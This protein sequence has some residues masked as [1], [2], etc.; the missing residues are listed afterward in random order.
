MGF[1]FQPQALQ[2]LFARVSACRGL[3]VGQRT[4]AHDALHESK[5][6]YG[7][8]A[9][10]VCVEDGALALVAVPR[11][12]AGSC[13]V[14]LAMAP[15]AQDEGNADDCHVGTKRNITT[16]FCGAKLAAVLVWEHANRAAPGGD[17]RRDDARQ[18]GRTPHGPAGSSSNP[19]GGFAISARCNEATF[20]A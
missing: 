15:G 6:V 16:W 18:R 5:P 4:G 2:E 1:V 19:R 8:L 13:D 14:D 12:A 17:G 7:G 9:R 20:R 3:A 10:C 11:R